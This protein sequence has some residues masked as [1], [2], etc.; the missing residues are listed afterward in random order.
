MEIID[1]L[2]FA[3]LNVAVALSSLLVVLWIKN[4]R[5]RSISKLFISLFVLFCSQIILVEILL[6]VFGALSYTNTSIVVYFVFFVIAMLLGKKVMRNLKVENFKKDF[7]DFFSTL[8]LFGPIV[9]LLFVKA[10]NAALQIP[11]E[12][13]SV[14]YHLPFITE[15]LQTGTL[16]KLYYSAFAGPISYY[17]SNYELLNLWS[18]LPFGNDFFANLFN[19]PF[20]IVLGT[21]IW[22][23]LRNF[24]VDRDIAIVSTAIPFYMPIFLHQAGIPLV[25]LF[26]ALVFIISIYFLQ[27]IY[28][29]KGGDSSDFL[30]F[31]L[32]VGLFIG[33][34]YLGLV[35]GIFIVLLLVVI[36]FLQ[37]KHK[38]INLLK[39]GI[40]TVIGILLTGSFFYIRNWINSGNPLFPVNLNFLGMKIFGGYSG[41]GV[42]EMLANTSLLVNLNTFSEIKAKIISFFYITGPYGLLSV[43]M[44][45][46]IVV[47]L[48]INRIYEKVIR[49]LQI[50]SNNKNLLF[51]GVGLLVYFYLYL[52]APYTYRDFFPNIRYAMPFLLI[53]VFGV[54]CMIQKLRFLK[55]T[56]F[57]FTIAT[58]IYSFLFLIFDPPEQ[59]AYTDRIFINYSILFEYKIPLF[60]LIVSII[61]SLYA[62]QVIY[63]E[64]KN[65]KWKFIIVGLLFL[66]SFVGSFKFIGFAYN[67]REGLR[68]YWATS[69]FGEDQTLLDIIRV[70]EWFNKNE[71]EAAIAYSGFNFHYY[72]YGRSFSRKVDYVNIN[73]CTKCRYVDYKNSENSIRR[74]PNYQYWFQ[75][76]HKM[77]KEY[78]VVNP[79]SVQGVQS[80]EFE[81]ANS[82]PDN[83]K[84]VF[85]ANDTYIYK[86]FYDQKVI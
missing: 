22:H 80:Y 23:I 11:L 46:I 45:I 47:Y 43:I 14:A 17:P 2:N 20:F 15:W 51:L 50:K 49:K 4:Y 68:E 12:Y 62:F 35:Y 66:I 67:E 18:F 70:A 72:L 36:A 48:L 79:V 34:K 41:A 8:I 53:G 27:E 29:N 3:G 5:V 56:F 75:N 74:D 7:P 55:K 39:A 54:A 30:F 19:F 84:K 33:T 1:F 21:V 57:I 10:F 59:I 78:L 71:P 61:A 64:I 42:N 76:L 65:R 77:E 24:G 26:F 16:S 6:G 73:E 40:I 44:P 52:K 82:N 25:D 63:S 31:G 58:F 38:K 83:F 37:V 9:F 86:I 81:W 13:D 69:Y 32:S 28:N 60:I 85:N